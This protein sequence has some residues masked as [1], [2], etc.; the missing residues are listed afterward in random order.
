M[1]DLADLIQSN[2]CRMHSPGRCYLAPS[3]CAFRK[4]QRVSARLRDCMRL[5][6]R[7]REDTGTVVNEWIR[8]AT[9]EHVI[10]LRLDTTSCISGRSLMRSCV[11][12]EYIWRV[13]PQMS[14]THYRE[15]INGVGRWVPLE[16]HPHA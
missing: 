1:P 3:A 12:S 16:R 5:I 8:T 15:I 14:D 7:I 2:G 13:L 4:G 11:A 10:F 9:N 6:G